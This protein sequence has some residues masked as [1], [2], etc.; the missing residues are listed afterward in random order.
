M[1]LVDERP[2]EVCTGLFRVV[3]IDATVVVCNRC[4]A[5][6]DWDEPGLQPARGQHSLLP[7]IPIGVRTPVDRLIG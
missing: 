6:V 4:G 1:T 7:Q 5:A 3:A 2:R